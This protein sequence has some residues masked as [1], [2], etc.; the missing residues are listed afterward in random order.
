MN[1]YT[2]YSLYTHATDEIIPEVLKQVAFPQNAIV[3]AASRH[4]IMCSPKKLN[5]LLSQI[6]APASRTSRHQCRVSHNYLITTA[7]AASMT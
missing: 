6:T 4:E 3:Y 2:L 5:D 7:R 1:G